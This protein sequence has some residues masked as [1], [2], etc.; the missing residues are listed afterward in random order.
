MRYC[1]AQAQVLVSWMLFY[2]YLTAEVMIQQ[3]VGVNISSDLYSTRCSQVIS[4]FLFVLH[5]WQCAT[6]NLK[7][8]NQSSYSHMHK[9]GILVFLTRTSF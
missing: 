5:S 2:N 7:S 3:K 9:C 8:K 6:L 4:D 1:N